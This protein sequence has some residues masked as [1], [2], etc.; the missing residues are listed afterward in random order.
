MNV[1]RRQILRYG[2]TVRGLY[3]DADIGAGR[4]IVRFG[5]RLGG[6]LSSSSAEFKYCS[7]PQG[8]RIFR[9][10]RPP[11]PHLVGLDRQHKRHRE[12]RSASTAFTFAPSFS[13]ATMART[14][15]ARA[16]KWSG[17][18]RLR[19]LVRR[20]GTPAPLDDIVDE[21]CIVLRRGQT[22]PVHASDGERG[23][24]EARWRHG[25]V[26]ICPYLDS[27][28]RRFAEARG[29]GV[30]GALAAFLQPRI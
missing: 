21:L 22:Q 20:R 25:L 4:L 2:G 29:C 19:G 18:M 7:Y 6:A 15:P 17:V 8:R 28:F 9:A 16:A 14:F 24:S 5:D 10:D 12:F 13:S 30:E 3:R 23:W 11:C 26:W 1:V 27:C